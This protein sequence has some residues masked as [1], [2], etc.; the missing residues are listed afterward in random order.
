[1]HLV[2]YFC[3]STCIGTYPTL[4]MNGRNR[5]AA[6]SYELI[7]LPTNVPGCFLSSCLGVPGPGVPGV[8][9]SPSHASPQGAQPGRSLGRHPCPV[10]PPLSW[11][12]ECLDWCLHALNGWSRMPRNWPFRNQ[13]DAPLFSPFEPREPPVLITPTKLHVIPMYSPYPRQ[14]HHHKHGSKPHHHHRLSMLILFSTT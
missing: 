1:M 6:N 10:Q 5:T 13:L 7:L 9:E 4:L 11:V 8:P 12:P 14:R 2:G 3:I